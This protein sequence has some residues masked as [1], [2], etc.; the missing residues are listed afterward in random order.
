LVNAVQVVQSRRFSVNID[1]E[2]KT[3]LSSFCDILEAQKMVS[4]ATQ[5]NGNNKTTASLPWK[6]S[7]RSRQEEDEGIDVDMMMVD[8]D[9]QRFEG[10]TFTPFKDK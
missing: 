6:S 4:S 8:D 7:K 3:I 10:R 5:N 9:E 2:L 1:D